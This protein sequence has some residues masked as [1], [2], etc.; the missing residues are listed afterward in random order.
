MEFEYW[1][2]IGFPVFFGLGWLAARIDIK[3]LLSE[4]RQLPESY[5]KG[6]N[7]LLNEQ[8]DRAIEAFIEVVKGDRESIELQFTLGG[9]FRRRG[10]SERAIRIHR[11]LLERG[12][13]TD[14]QRLQA[15]FELGQ[16]Y[17]KAGLLDRAEAAF[18]K[19][20]GTAFER[21]AMIF[22]VEIFQQEREWE[23]A[24]ATTRA[25]EGKDSF[26]Q[27]AIANFYCEWANSLLNQSRAEEAKD[28]LQL[29]LEFNRRCVRASLILGDLYAAS[30][31][32]SEAI[33]VWKRIEQQDP[34]YLALCA[35]KLL[36]SY[37]AIG[38]VEEGLV[39]LKGF[40]ASFPS[41]DLL[42][43]VFQSVMELEGASSAHELVKEEL[44]RNPTLLG[45][46]RLLEAQLVNAPP[47]RRPDLELIRN[48]IHNHTLRLSRFQCSNCGFKARQFHWKCPGCGGWET[49]PPRRSEEFEL[50]A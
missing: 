33:A 13:I 40:L 30:G 47:E 2:V 16:D 1:W 3:H 35:A 41:L 14:S 34:P 29:A 19:L 39:L 25:L 4:S 43:V 46:D 22:L 18:E 11:S 27:K 12:D 7:F 10:E 9:M 24:I 38:A 44:R 42:D 8:P 45:L 20:R 15:L 50:T 32:H 48:L 26:Q 17:L 37:R 6:L 28:K 36:S 5:F 31:N 23:K 49:Y 21:D